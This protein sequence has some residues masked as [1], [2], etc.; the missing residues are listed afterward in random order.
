[1]LSLISIIYGCYHK[2]GNATNNKCKIRDLDVMDID[3]A[4]IRLNR[5][6]K[7]LKIGYVNSKRVFKEKQIYSLYLVY[8]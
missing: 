1:M 2:F 3:K 8:Y 7:K 4:R 6:K 5:G